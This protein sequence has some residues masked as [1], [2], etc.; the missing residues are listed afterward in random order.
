MRGFRL[1]I[2]KSDGS[3]GAVLC[4]DTAELIREMP[5]GVERADPA[6]RLALNRVAIPIAPDVVLRVNLGQKLFDQKP[7][8]L[9]SHG[10]VLDGSQAAPL[11]C[12][13]LN[14]QVRHQWNLLLIDQIVRDL[15]NPHQ[16]RAEDTDLLVVA[17]TQ[18]LPVLPDHQRNW[19]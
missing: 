19:S 1:M 7:G 13:R 9:V 6:G 2:A 11:Q 17:A 4:G 8:V 15:K 3:E 16:S 10:I 5:S 12:S 18:P 14:E